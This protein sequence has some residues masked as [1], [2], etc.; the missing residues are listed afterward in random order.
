MIMSSNIHLSLR[1]GRLTK[2]LVLIYRFRIRQIVELWVSGVGGVEQRIRKGRKGARARTLWK[3]DSK[4]LGSSR[5][6]PKIL[7]RMVGV[8]G[9]GG[10]GVQKG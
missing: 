3:V 4:S 9:G 7:Q 1:F 2:T 10:G 5:L 8:G 6:G